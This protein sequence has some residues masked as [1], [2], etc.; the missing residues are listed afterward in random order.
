MPIYRFRPVLKWD[1]TILNISF[2]IFYDRIPYNSVNL[3][4]I[5]KTLEN[6][7]NILFILG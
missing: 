7:F 4:Y 6:N 5:N 1:I 3:K 2:F